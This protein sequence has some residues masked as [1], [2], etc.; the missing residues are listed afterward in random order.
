MQAAR[1]R[2]VVAGA[3]RHAAEV[4]AYAEDLRRCGHPLDLLGC[5]DDTVPKGVVRSLRVLGPMQEFESSP[6]EFFEQLN[7][8][9]ATGDNAA[10]CRIVSRLESLYGGRCH[11]TT[12][13]HPLASVG[14]DAVIGEGAC[15]APTA[16]LT[17]RVRMGRHCIVNVKA[18]VSHDCIIGD[19]VNI[20]PGATLCGDVEIGDGAYIGAGATVI[21]R[22]RIGSGTVIGAGAVVVRDLPEHVTAVGVPARII[23]KHS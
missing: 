23:S 22:I 13:I 3:G 6:D 9:T 16:V 15:I 20:N 2:L 8:I 11:F 10:R 21:E 19:Y 5:L 12:L 17:A 4:C 7:W 18:S 1:G 14:T